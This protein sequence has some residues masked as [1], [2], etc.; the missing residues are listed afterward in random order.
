[1]RR[2]LILSLASAALAAG[3]VAAFAA[4][5]TVRL[6]AK[7][8]ALAFNVK[9]LTA[10]AG[11]VTIVMS[12]PRGS[13]FSHGIAVEGKGVDKDGKV[14]SAGKRSVL[15]LR[16]KKGRYTFYCPVPGH[17]AAGMKGVLIVK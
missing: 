14:V 11:K 10:K 13:D 6:S 4:G 2:I 8:H 1:M 5:G 16:L 7:P 15:T 12:N 9:R 17:R 3:A